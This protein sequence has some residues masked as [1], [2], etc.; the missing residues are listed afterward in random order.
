[1]RNENEIDELFARKLE[2][3][4]V[5]PSAGAWDKMELGLHNQKKPNMVLWYR[6]AAA[7]LFLVVSTFTWIYFTNDQSDNIT[8]ANAPIEF[9]NAPYP[10]Q[11]VNKTP[12]FSEIIT[13]Q[14]AEIKKIEKNKNRMQPPMIKEHLSDI[15]QNKASI[16]MNEAVAQI[17]ESKDQMDKSILD[18]LPTIKD[19]VA[20]VTTEELRKDALEAIDKQVSNT[21]VVAGQQENPTDET[22]NTIGKDVTVAMDA[23]NELPAVSITYLGRNEK[24]KKKKAGKFS[25]KKV[26]KS[27][28]RLAD[29]DLIAGLRNAKDDLIDSGIKSLDD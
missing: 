17:K 22:V 12:D 5:A 14:L 23:S 8:I 28:K 4:R 25:L 6:I 18:N 27:A 21:D 9:L 3:A 26:F 29:G 24:P 7:V 19:L 11:V 13:F 1:M 16:K 15:A 10:K 2:T 20:E